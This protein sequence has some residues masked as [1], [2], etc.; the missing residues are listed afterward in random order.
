MNQIDSGRGEGMAT[1]GDLLPSATRDENRVRAHADERTH[2]LADLLPSA[3]RGESRA[4]AQRDERTHTLADLIELATRPRLPVRTLPLDDCLR[5]VAE[6]EASFVRQTARVSDV[7]F[8]DDVSLTFGKSSLPLD[9]AGLGRL[10]A[11]I[12]APASYLTTLP[13]DLQRR[14]LTHHLRTRF[15]AQP[16]VTVVSRD[17]RFE[18]LVDGSLCTLSATE[19]IGTIADSLHSLAGELQVR[20]QGDDCPAGATW[21]DGASVQIQILCVNRGFDAVPGDIVRA[22][23]QVRH[24]PL[25]EHATWIEGFFDRLECANGMVTRE[26][27][28]KNGGAGRTRRLPVNHPDGRQ[29][30]LAQLQRLIKVEWEALAERMAAVQ[31]LEKKTVERVPQLFTRWLQQARISASSK[32]L[33]SVQ[34][35]LLGSWGADGARPTRWAAVNAFTEVGTHHRDLPHGTRRLLAGLGGLL[36][37]GDRHLCDQCLSRLTRSADSGAAAS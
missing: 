26:C 25:G 36:A 15:S 28:G 10:A 35:R 27:I 32:R 20:S 8:G 17:G 7:T 1:L 14:L 12:A 21:I 22:G 5:A 4:R 37:F 11:R 33:T 23:I 34:S 6:R 13:R 3:T 18:T 9:R 24:S 31:A 16:E 30:L 29:L 2:T 19:A